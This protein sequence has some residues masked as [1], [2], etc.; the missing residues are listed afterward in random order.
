MSKFFFTERG[1]DLKGE[2]LTEI[3]TEAIIKPLNHT[4]SSPRAYYPE[5]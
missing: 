2:L 5:N 1:L 3:K 4:P